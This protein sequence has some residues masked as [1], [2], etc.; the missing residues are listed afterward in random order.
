MLREGAL[1]VKNTLLINMDRGLQLP[2]SDCEVVLT[3][4]GLHVGPYRH[5][6]SQAFLCHRHPGGSAGA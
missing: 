5:R 2:S 4:S 6:G 3:W 1:F